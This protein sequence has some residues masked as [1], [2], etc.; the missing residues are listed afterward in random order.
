MNDD[1][2]KIIQQNK[3]LS[4]YDKI[5][6]EDSL[7]ILNQ[8][9]NELNSNN[10]LNL[11]HLLLNLSNIL[12]RDISISKD[13]L[14]EAILEEASIILSRYSNIYRE[15][16]DKNMYSE[17]FLFINNYIKKVINYLNKIMITDKEKFEPY[18]SF[19]DNG[20]TPKQK[21]VKEQK[22]EMT[23]ETIQN[24]MHLLNE[25]VRNYYEIY[26]NKTLIATFTDEQVIKF[27]I[28]E[29]NLAHLLGVNLK[30]IVKN[31]EFV[32]LFHITSSEIECILDE[33]YTLDPNG[34]AAISV[35]HKII[36]ISDGNLLQ[37]E[38][39]RLKKIDNYE[40]RYMKYKKDPNQ[41]L[42][43]YAKINYKSKA[44]IDY[45]PLEEL[46]LIL[47]FPEGYRIINSDRIIPNHSLV[48][49]KN[50]LSDNFKYT[51][52][53]SNYDK[54]ND[55]R[56]FLSLL[57]KKPSSM[58]QYQ[59]DAIPAIS[60]SVEMISDDG[61]GKTI[62]RDFSIEEQIRFLLEVQNDFQKL[63]LQEVVEYFRNL[64][65]D[66]SKKGKK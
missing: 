29:A 17:V 39:D 9:N 51:S 36:D 41:A 32:D 24:T 53:L 50:H 25:A 5:V 44:F 18:V 11:N 65:D 20:R 49:S 38:Y 37:F 1:I 43:V 62:R 6:I 35:L 54:L 64:S 31:K 30:A 59:K 28:M 22:L 12:G 23:I 21:E 52:L 60:T 3:S 10:V 56:Y 26:H 27:K 15:L 8:I 66:Y 19:F 47:N 14:E 16:L 13:K 34:S 57:L 4:D 48:V 33:T 63:D 58:E 46:S 42:G 55:R 40:Y 61:T 2:K 7:Q 45:R